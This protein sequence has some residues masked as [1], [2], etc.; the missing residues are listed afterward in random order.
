MIFK[1]FELN[2]I[3]L[4]KN[5]FILLYGKNE[6]FKNQTVE[7][8]INKKNSIYNYDE[9]TILDNSNNFFENLLSK[10]LF[11]SEKIIII[12]R[13][14]DKI[15]EIILNLN[16]KNINDLIVILNSDKDGE[17]AS[18]IITNNPEHYRLIKTND[19][20]ELKEA[21]KSFDGV[22]R[23]QIQNEIWEKH[24]LEKWKTHIE[25]CIDKTKEKFYNKR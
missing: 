5:K 25:K 16:E 15:L 24:S 10:S 18:K 6:G 22:D 9:K 21:I 19:A 13:V 20:D 8:L 1:N 14:T 12:K 4:K 11:E 7:N 23:Q 17:H 3:N 2:K